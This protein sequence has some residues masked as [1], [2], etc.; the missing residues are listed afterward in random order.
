MKEYLLRE[1][2]VSPCILALC[3]LQRTP[4]PSP[5]SLLCLNKNSG[6]M[7]V[8][9]AQQKWL[10]ALGKLARAA[11]PNSE[12]SFVFTLTIIL[13]DRVSWICFFAP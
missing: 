1:K 8:L 3:S 5:P 7:E 11:L 10:K 6:R 4:L 12:T 2:I 13:S 9:H